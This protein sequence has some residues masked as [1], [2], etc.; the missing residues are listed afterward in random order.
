MRIPRHRISFVSFASSIL[1][2][3]V[4]AIAAPPAEEQIAA[5]VLPAPPE[6]RNDARVLGYD[7][8]GRLVTLRA[9]DG[10][11]VCLADDPEKES[12]H[13][14]CY[15]RDLEPFMAR[16]RE[17]RADGLD[18]AALEAQRKKEIEA[19]RLPMPEEP[20][21]LYTLT[22]PAGSWNPEERKLSGANRVVVLYVPYATAESTGLS[23]TQMVPGAPW[24][25]AEGE[26][27][28][29]VMIVLGPDEAE[30]GD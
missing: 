24:I 1:F 15:H 14:A 16:G 5:A 28:A 30:K 23:P 27:W 26:P 10:E 9:G 3:A 7:E 21:A 8:A 22:A 19:G 17:L 29:H 20:R 6:L 12:F 18:R 25:M 4:A 13:V 2:L 11:L